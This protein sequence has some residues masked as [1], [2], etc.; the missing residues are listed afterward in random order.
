[1]SVQ[2]V[3]TANTANNSRYWDPTSGGFTSVSE[4]FCVVGST[5][6]PLTGTSSWSVAFP[7]AN[8]PAGGQYTARATATDVAGNVSA[9]DVHDFFVDYNPATAVFVNTARP[10]DTGLGTTPATA[11]KTIAAAIGDVTATRNVIVVTVGNYA[12]TVNVGALNPVTLRGG[13]SGTSWLRAAPPA[14]GN[15]NNPANVSITTGTGGAETTGIVFT[16]STASLQQFT[17]NSG[18]ASGAGSSAYGVRALSSASVTVTNVAITASAGIAGTPGTNASTV[19]SSGGTGGNGGSNGDG[20]VRGAGGSIG[21]GVRTGGVGGQGAPE[22]NATG[23]AGIQG[24]VVSGAGGNGGPGGSGSGSSGTDARGGRGGNRI[25]QAAGGSVQVGQ[26]GGAKGTQTLVSGGSTFTYGAGGNGAAGSAVD[27]NN[28]GHGGGGGG[29]GGGQGCGICNDDAGAGGG[30]GGGAGGAGNPGTGGTAGG[31]SFALY[32]NNATV[33]V[34]NL[35]RLTSG[36]GGNGGAAGSGSNGGPGGTGGNGGNCQTAQEGGAGGGG[37]GGGSGMGGFGGGGGA[38]GPSI[39]VYENGTGVVTFSGG[40]PTLTKGTAGTGG[41]QR[42][43]AASPA[44]PEPVE[45]GVTRPSQRTPTATT[46]T[47]VSMVA[48]GSWAQAVPRRPTPR[49]T[50]WP[51]TLGQAL[52]RTSSAPGTP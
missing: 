43:R 25:T 37:G 5:N 47:W 33:T 10:D 45:S 14:V 6:C 35:S 30:G 46:A 24:Q 44:Q 49:S 39:V 31:G 34:N 8:I 2:A 38:G 48:R 36:N 17:V 18:T 22:G 7:I 20:S 23:S 27:A 28:N 16:G 42:A 52:V 19:G 13:Y 50:A 40:T 51:G 21:S 1:M 29:G 12:N 9:V 26:S 41:A 11:E 4:V 3:N 15:I 32:A